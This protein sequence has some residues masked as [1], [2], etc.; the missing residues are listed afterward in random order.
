MAALRSRVRTS[1]ALDR[2]LKGLSAGKGPSP[3]AGMK[4]ELPEATGSVEL[5]RCVTGVGGLCGPVRGSYSTCTCFCVRRFLGWFE[6]GWLACKHA[7][8]E[9]RIPRRSRSNLQYLNNNH[10]TIMSPVVG[11]SSHDEYDGVATDSTRP[12]GSVASY[13]LLF[14][15]LTSGWILRHASAPLDPCQ[16]EGARWYRAA[17]GCNSL[18]RERCL[19][20]GEQRARRGGGGGGVWRFT[21]DPRRVGAVR[22]AILQGDAQGEEKQRRR[23]GEDC[24]H[25]SGGAKPNRSMSRRENG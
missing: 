23:K 7:R 13:R 12:A 6:I 8:S 15:W 5:S 18:P 11:L 25:S 22:R 21:A 4:G 3:L 9:C 2:Q 20:I 19:Q 24:A 14:P 16:L 1:A 17:A 10:I